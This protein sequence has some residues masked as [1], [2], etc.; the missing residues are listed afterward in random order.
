MLSVEY[1]TW[2]SV[3]QQFQPRLT[4]VISYPTQCLFH[5]EWSQNYKKEELQI[6]PPASSDL[7]ES[8]NSTHEPQNHSQWNSPAGIKKHIKVTAILLLPQIQTNMN[9]TFFLTDNMQWQAKIK[10]TNPQKSLTPAIFSFPL[11]T[12]INN[13][14]LYLYTRKIILYTKLHF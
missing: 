11:S 14:Y 6:L 1:S 13:S 7:L 3:I 9:Y 5:N 12:M 10:I 8:K 4:R 2:H